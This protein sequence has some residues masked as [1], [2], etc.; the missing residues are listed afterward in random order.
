MSGN[1]YRRRLK[2]AERKGFVE[3]WAQGWRGGW[4]S[5]HETGFTEGK[6]GAYFDPIDYGK[7]VRF[8]QQFQKHEAMLNGDPDFVPPHPADWIVCAVIAARQ[9]QAKDAVT[10][11]KSADS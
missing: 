1:S 8:V 2:K 11:V 6:P 5:G 4:L 9:L 7:A 3:G 10:N